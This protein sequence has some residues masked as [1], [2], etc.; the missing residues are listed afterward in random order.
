MY[1]DELIRHCKDTIWHISKK[2]IINYPVPKVFG[3]KIPGAISQFNKRMVL[4]EPFVCELEDILLSGE[5]PTAITNESKTINESTIY[6]TPPINAEEFVRGTKNK[7]IHNY[8][9]AF[10]LVNSKNK[11]YYHWI[12]ERLPLLE[13]YEFYVKQKKIKPKIIIHKNLTPW[14]KDSLRAIGYNENDCMGWD[15]K[16]SQVKKFIISSMRRFAKQKDVPW[17]TLSPSSCKWIRK[18]IL[19]YYKLPTNPK[20]GVEKIYISRSNSPD[21]KVLNED[22]VFKFLK[23]QGFKKYYLEELTFE[24]QVRLFSKADIIVAPHGAGLTNI[25]WAPKTTKVFEIMSK[26]YPRSDYFQISNALGIK[27]ALFIC[28]DITRD[29]DISVNLTFFKEFIK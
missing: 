28:N 6:T 20:K 15:N 19:Q 12:I 25:L 27:Y 16:N 18:R 10:S 11:N 2:E 13:G 26:N 23:Q 4:D 29:H 21:R 9:Y 17:D 8:T 7:V 1:R 14:Q 24:E 3:D 5:Y 22:A